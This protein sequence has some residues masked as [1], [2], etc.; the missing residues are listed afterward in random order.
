MEGPQNWE[1]FESFHIKLQKN[2]SL[3]IREG[4]IDIDEAPADHPAK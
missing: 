1:I 2:R 4:R 3:E